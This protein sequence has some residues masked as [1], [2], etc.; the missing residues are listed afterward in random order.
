MIWEDQNYD[1]SILSDEIHIWKA[2]LDELSCKLICM[3]NILSKYEKEKAG[4]YFFAKDANRFI[5]ARSVLR[6]LLGRYLDYSP[7]QINFAFNEFGK[8]FLDH[9]TAGVQIHFNVSHSNRFALFAIGKQEELGVDI[10]MHRLDFSSHA[11]ANRFFSPTEIDSLKELDKLEF[12]QAF[13]NCW[14][15][16]E[17]YIKAKGLGLS[18]GLDSF[19]VETGNVPSPKLMI[20]EFYPDDTYVYS[21]R[22]FEPA[23]RYSAA[24]ATNFVPQRIRFLSVNAKKCQFS[25]YIL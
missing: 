11:I 23:H 2:D 19:A 7:T 18:L 16:K 9:G 17:A 3:D 15:R 5:T 10:E 8:P 13:F 20:S 25:K 24:L 14:T 22:S 1:F 21:F 12:C 4:R 6:I